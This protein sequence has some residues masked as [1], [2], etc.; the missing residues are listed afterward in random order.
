MPRFILD[1]TLANVSHSIGKM[2]I[3]EA[4]LL[5]D[6]RWPWIM[7]VP[8]RPDCV[9]LHDLKASDLAQAMDDMRDVANCLKK[10]TPC[11][12]INVGSLGNMV[13]QLH[14]HVIA[15][16]E[17]DPNWPGPVWGFEKAIPYDDTAREVFLAKLT[18]E[19]I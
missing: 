17:G 19:L 3:C 4:R 1:E 13:R 8:A 10:L 15:R 2:R 12:K 6:A 9:D 7:L 14:I 18:K 11:Q 5:D 16:N